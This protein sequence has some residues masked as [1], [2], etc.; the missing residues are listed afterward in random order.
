[1]LRSISLGRFSAMVLFC[2][3][4]T[5][6]S[7]VLVLTPVAIAQTISPR[8]VADQVYQRLPELPRENQYIR[9]DNNRQATDST[10]VERFIQYH[11]GVKGRS[12]QFRLD[13]KITLADYLGMN[14]FLEPNTYPGKAFLKANP[15]EGDRALIQKLTRQQRDS[16]LQALVDIYTSGA[17]QVTVSPLPPAAS[18]GPP[19]IPA[20]KPTLQ[21]L[22]RN[23]DSKLLAPPNVTAPSQPRPTGGAQLLMP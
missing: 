18:P 21:S 16:L 5:A 1:M 4:F 23:G 8:K 3:I 13:W 17:S 22:P 7:S 11:N 19:P 14:D 15:L 12:P 10:L 9:Q 20:S 6:L 2:A